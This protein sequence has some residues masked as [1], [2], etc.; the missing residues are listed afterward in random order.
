MALARERLCFVGIGDGEV[1]LQSQNSCRRRHLQ[2]QIGIVQ[3]GHE[4]GQSWPTKYGVVGGV[5]VG[6]VEVDVL[7]T[8]VASRVE[9]YREGDLSKRYECP[10]RYHTP[11]GGIGGSEVFYSK[12]QLL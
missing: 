10:V 11:E 12:A 7:D 5:E 6:D 8:K 1:G 3:Y 4:L 2:Y 9:L